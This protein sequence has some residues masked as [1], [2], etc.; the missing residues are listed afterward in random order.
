[1][2]ILPIVFNNQRLIELIINQAT[3]IPPAPGFDRPY[4]T[5]GTPAGELTGVIIG[6]SIAPPPNKTTATNQDYSDALIYM[7]VEGKGQAAIKLSEISYI[8]WRT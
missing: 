6:Y 4:G 7:N 2:A 8:H 5:I 3:G 1:M